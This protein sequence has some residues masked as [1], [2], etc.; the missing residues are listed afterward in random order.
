MTTS[1]EQGH[2]NEIRKFSII[3]SYL[4]G[5]PKDNSTRSNPTLQQKSSITLHG[6]EL[7]KMNIV[8]V[9]DL[10]KNKQPKIPLD[11]KKTYQIYELESNGQPVYW[12]QFTPNIP[13]VKKE[14]NLGDNYTAPAQATANDQNYYIPERMSA[15]NDGSYG[16]A[17]PRTLKE[18]REL[19]ETLN[20]TL[21]EQ[22]RISEENR[23]ED[24]IL[25]DKQVEDIRKNH[26]EE[27][28][29]M[30]LA[31]EMDKHSQDV[32]IG[33]LEASVDNWMKEYYG[34]QNELIA[35]KTLLE[36]AKADVES[37]RT[38]FNRQMKL[39][40][41]KFDFQIFQRDQEKA[42][43]EKINKASPGGLADGFNFMDF[44][45]TVPAL[46]ATGQAIF[47]GGNNNNPQPAQ[48]APQPITV[49][50]VQN[51]QV[52][53]AQIQPNQVQNTNTNGVPPKPAAM[54]PP[55]APQIE[56]A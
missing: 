27:L 55:V 15:N 48:N 30:R 36:K 8:S 35:A 11:P 7:K 19:Y 56:G 14:R 4:I 37:M 23:R 31:F 53:P 25:R 16:T 5:V 47:G 22:L 32:Q 17:H 52:Q 49:Q 26:A 6:S 43:Q 18:Q 12:D 28:E 33:K 3:K 41:D 20:S 13:S 39:E 10:I 29:R 34:V 51:N 42:A 44:L 21:K 9:I 24:H 2:E 45:K 50:P 40:K 38:D 1:I 54:A 46:V